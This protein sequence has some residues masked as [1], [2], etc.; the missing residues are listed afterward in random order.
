MVPRSAADFWNP[1]ES[2]TAELNY[3]FVKMSFGLWLA[4]GRGVDDNRII[5]AME[6][7]FGNV[8]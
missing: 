1:C 2:V 4:W 8:S 7:I 6:I 5:I 3:G